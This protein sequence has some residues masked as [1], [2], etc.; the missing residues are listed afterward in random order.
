MKSDK[1]G[2]IYWKSFFLMFAIVFGFYA[3]K[4]LYEGI[5]EGHWETILIIM[6]LLFLLFFLFLF[7]IVGNNFKI[8][9]F[10]EGRIIIKDKKEP[11][12]V[13]WS[14]VESLQLL[15]LTNPPIYIFWTFL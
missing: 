6:A 11:I 1:L 7:R 10:K 2:H 12:E 9:E 15:R 13:L 5:K 8:V 14:D 3:I 4:L